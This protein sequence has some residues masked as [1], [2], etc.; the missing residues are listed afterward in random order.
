MGFK[1]I[2]TSVRKCKRMN[3]NTFKWIPTVGIGVL[4]VSQIFVTNVYIKNLVSIGLYLNHWKGLQ[5]KILQMNLHCPFGDW[6]L[7]LWIKLCFDPSFGLVINVG[8]QKRMKARKMCWNSHVWVWKNAK[9]VSLK[10]SEMGITCGVPNCFEFLG[11]KCGWQI[12]FKLNIVYIVKTFLKCRYQ[13]CLGGGDDNRTTSWGEGK[14]LNWNLHQNSP[15]PPWNHI[16]TPPQ[17]S[18]HLL[19]R[20]ILH[21]LFHLKLLS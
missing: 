3:P 7:K 8:A 12:I 2:L 14:S 4:W 19:S 13:R 6:K 11:L 17:V 16:H 5:M 20:L 9:E 18:S 1:H 15:Q 21:P 10:H